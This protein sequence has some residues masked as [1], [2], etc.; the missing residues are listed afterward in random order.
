VSIAGRALEEG[1]EL[2]TLKDVPVGVAVVRLGVADDL[3][4]TVDGAVGGL[5]D[6]LGPAVGVQVV[7][8]HLRVVGAGPDVVA[9]VDAPQPGAVQLVGVDVHVPGVAGPGVVLG[10]GRILL[11]DDL[12]RAVAVDITLASLAR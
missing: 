7:D 3:A 10:V 11:Q 2:G 8:H 4:R 5:H 12:V 6:G 9:E 1:Q